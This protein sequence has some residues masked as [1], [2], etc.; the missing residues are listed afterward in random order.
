VRVK[1][2]AARLEV[3]SATVY[4]LIAAGKLRCVRVGLGRGA[5]RILDEHIAE[6]LQKAEPGAKQPPVPAR[7]PVLKQLSINSGG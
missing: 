2:V 7:K 1:E 5:I 6:Y 4:G 3:S